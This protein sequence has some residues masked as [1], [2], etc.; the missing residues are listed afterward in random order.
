MIF[1]EVPITPDMLE[2]AHTLA[3]QLGSLKNSIR[4]GEGNLVGFLGEECFLAAFPKATRE[5]SFDFDIRLGDKRLE[6]KTKDRTVRPQP[7]FEVSVSAYNKNQKADYYVFVSLFRQ[8]RVFYRGYLLG[9]M[10]PAEYLMNASFL[11]EGMIDPSN[12]F[13]VRA[14]CYNLPIH[15]LNRF[16][17]R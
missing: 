16:T 1:R 4:E 2:R 15:K 9:F 5:N 12:Q 13:T 8:G 7:D 3:T 14:S 10:K 11:R 17:V 6:V